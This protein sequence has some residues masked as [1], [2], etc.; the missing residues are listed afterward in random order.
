[1]TCRRPSPGA[2]RNRNEDTSARVP[3]RPI[4]DLAIVLEHYQTIII[5]LAETIAHH[6]NTG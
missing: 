4:T 1:V 5:D 3:I 6:R 2:L